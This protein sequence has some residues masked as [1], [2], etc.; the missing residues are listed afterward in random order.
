MLG[1]FLGPPMTGM[2]EKTPLDGQSQG[3][4]PGMAEEAAELRASLWEAIQLLEDLRSAAV[5]YVGGR[6]QQGWSE[7]LGLYFHVFGHNSV[8]SEN[9][10]GMSM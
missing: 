5:S 2:V 8:T 7:Q 9:N 1:P 3:R 10:W 4:S 6:R